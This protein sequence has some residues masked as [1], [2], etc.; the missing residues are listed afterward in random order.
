MTHHTSRR[1]LSEQKRSQKDSQSAN[2]IALHP[3]THNH[4][5]HAQS[6]SVEDAAIAIE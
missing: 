6:R 1:G 4:S 5:L 3:Q 2:I